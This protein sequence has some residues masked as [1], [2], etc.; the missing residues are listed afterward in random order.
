MKDSAT[1]FGPSLS[2]S[3]LPLVTEA[4]PDADY[5]ARVFVLVQDEKAVPEMELITPYRC[6]GRS[7]SEG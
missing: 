5:D 4:F 3:P 6:L 1:C 7:V 2:V